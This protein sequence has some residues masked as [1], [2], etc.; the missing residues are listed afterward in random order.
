MNRSLPPSM[1]LVGALMLTGCMRGQVTDG[2][3]PVALRPIDSPLP[4]P[5][6]APTPTP[7][8]TP[9]PAPTPPAAVLPPLS[10]V[11][12][13][14]DDNHRVGVNHWP[15]RDPTTGARGEPVDGIP[16]YPGNDPPSTYHVHSH[17][18]IF[19]DKQALAIP[20]DIGVVKLTPTSTCVYSLHTH[21]HSG[22]VHVEGPAPDRFTLGQ[23]FHIWGRPLQPDNVAGLTG[24]PIVVYVTDYNGVVT[25]A[26]G[27]W[28]DIE[29]LSHREI[30]I[31][32]GEPIDEIPNY[33]WTAH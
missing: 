31:Q 23:F 21:N 17:L 18:S 3:A 30:T 12:I 8:P 13:D 19:L 24:K 20:E 27:D 22:K 1:A 26:T 5:S 7:T 29:L 16:C 14:L 10:P 32:V 33:N 2:P 11:V 6:P 28:N 15:D 25:L 9:T 4:Q